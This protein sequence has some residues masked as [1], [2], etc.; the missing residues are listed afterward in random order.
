MLPLNVWQHILSFHD[1]PL[2]LFRY[3]LVCKDFYRISRSNVLWNRHKEDVLALIP[4]LEPIFDKYGSMDPK[5]QMKMPK[6]KRQKLTWIR[7]RGIWSVFARYLF[8]RS[9]SQI[10]S[11]KM[12]THMMNG[13][14]KTA[15]SPSLIL[16]FIVPSSDNTQKD[17]K[18]VRCMCTR[19]YHFWWLGIQK[20]TKRVLIYKS[21]I[22]GEL[23]YE[24]TI[25]H[26][27]YN[28]SNIV[29]GNVYIDSFIDQRM[30]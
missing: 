10:L 6:T 17:F 5:K 25:E 26:L 14:I 4:D 3:A 13:I 20:R 27:L 23:L 16:D 24:T 29:R 15:F 8:S 12:S 2:E 1:T 7:P 9:I 19:T 18:C 30:K 28:F 11:T 21:R 22:G